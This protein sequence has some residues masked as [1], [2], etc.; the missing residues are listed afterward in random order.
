MT[1]DHGGVK[2]LVE[3]KEV[4]LG[5]L[6]H[7]QEEAWRIDQEDGAVD[8]ACNLSSRQSHAHARA[9]GGVGRLSRGAATVCD[10]LRT[11]NK[12]GPCACYMS[13]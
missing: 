5:L 3:P 11:A 8:M 6:E 10:Q 12:G 1:G 2:V 9:R 7:V 4:R 13:A